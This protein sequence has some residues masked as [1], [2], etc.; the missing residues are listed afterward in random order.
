MEGRSGCRAVP[1]CGD[2]DPSSRSGRLHHR[3]DDVG[4]SSAVG[5]GRQAVARFAAYG[6]VRVGDIIFETL[7][8]ALRMAGRVETKTDDITDRVVDRFLPPGDKEGDK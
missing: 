7:S 1:R 4:G 8:I 2:I 5:K 6:G 3:V